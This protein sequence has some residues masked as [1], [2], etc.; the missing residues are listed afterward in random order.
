MSPNW[1][2]VNSALLDTWVRAGRVDVVAG[3]IVLRGTAERFAAEEAVR[4]VSEATA[5][6]DPKRW[7]GSVFRVADLVELGAEVVDRSLVVDDLAYDLE[8]GFLVAPLGQEVS[9]AEL[10]ARARE[11]SQRPSMRPQSDEEL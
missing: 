6:G 1:L 11:L 3:A 4:V 8:P 5:T 10:V 2:F 9:R 7:V